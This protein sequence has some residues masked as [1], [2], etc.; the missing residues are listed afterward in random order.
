[1]KLRPLRSPALALSLAGL[2]LLLV[3]PPGAAAQE[4]PPEPAPDTAPGGPE[5]EAAAAPDSGLEVF[6]DTVDV[7]VV[8]LD[9]VVTDK[10]GQ[11]VTGLA[12]EDFE[13]FEDGKP[14]TI[15]N[16][17]SV[18]EGHQRQPSQV[19]E[20]PVPERPA[21][22]ALE[23]PEE[24]RLHLVVY[25]D[26]FN[27]APAH[28][29]RVLG[30][31]GYFLSTKLSRNDRVML[32]SYDRTLKIRRPFTGDADLIARGLEELELVTGHALARE[33]ERRQALEM[34][35][36][37][38][39]ASQAMSYARM[40]AESVQNDLTFTLRALRDLINNLAGLP[41]RKAILY[42]SDGLPM[43]AGQDVFFAVDGKFSGGSSFMTDSMHFDA[44]RQFRELTT[45]ANASRVTFYTIDAAG[46]RVGGS[47]AAE[48]GRAVEGPMVD[49]TY[50]ANQQSSLRYLAD[51]TGGLAIVNS[52][53]ATPGLEKVARD[54]DTYYSLGFSPAH[55]ASGRYYDVKVR[56][57]GRR[58]LVVRHREGYRDKTIESR[59]ADGTVAALH[60]ASS[61]NPLGAN[62]RIGD[63]R[64]QEE[65]R[66]YVVPVD[67][68]IPIGSLVLVPGE[69]THE[70]RVRLFIA[71]IDDQGDSSPVQQVTV[72][73]SIPNAEVEQARGQVFRYS[74]PL[75]MRSGSHRVAVGL[76]D[77]VGGQETFITS[78]VEVGH[79]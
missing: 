50:I 31:V 68:E 77:E 63:P 46:L 58:D 20:L 70:S 1:M 40:Y 7:R 5:P 9:V 35:G 57:K 6:V 61:S 64:R 24:Q 29:N 32:V 73:I 36:E 75:L 38:D 62:L 66:H 41:G 2:A 4:P 44:S 55:A 21:P 52:N 34:I 42:V 17:Y 67:V 54:F 39:S 69:G 15:S 11:P 49:S 53:R 13:L 47:Y 60:F 27:I 18:E 72:P 22:E 16:F 12:R 76:R 79:S 30:E 14:V 8:N 45:L 56:V 23:I 33:S 65:G 43:V 25:I 78:H 3:L 10:K 26:N 51:S 19:A 74:V 37:S 48:H 71:A 59:M 28:R